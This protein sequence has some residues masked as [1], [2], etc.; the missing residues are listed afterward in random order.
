METPKT[1]NSQRKTMTRKSRHLVGCLSLTAS[2][3]LALRVLRIF[4]AELTEFG[5]VKLLLHL[6]LVPLRIMRDPP[7][8]GALQLGHVFL[9]LS[10]IRQTYR[11]RPIPYT[12]PQNQKKGK[13]LSKSA[14]HRALLK[15]MSR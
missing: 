10:H 14:R 15:N 7:A 13:G 11:L 1:N 6:L 3:L 4:P 9:N 12:L 2:I 5:K 8:L